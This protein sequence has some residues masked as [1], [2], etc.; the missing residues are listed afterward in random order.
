MALS[1]AFIKRSKFLT[2]SKDKAEIWLIEV[3]DPRRSNG[4]VPIQY[5]RARNPTDVR[6]IV[7]DYMQRYRI[8]PEL[9]YHE[10]PELEKYFKI[11][12][13]V[14]PKAD[15]AVKPV[16]AEGIKED[17]KEDTEDK[18]DDNADSVNTDTPEL[19]GARK[20]VL[21]SDDFLSE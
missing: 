17:I 6:R 15:V 13:K 12:R 3:F 16:S 21:V 1:Q 9:V 18:E 5:F 2:V 8:L 19:H 11:A 14:L 7:R 10:V 4:V 20:A